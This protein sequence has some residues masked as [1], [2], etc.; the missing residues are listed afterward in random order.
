MIVTKIRTVVALGI[1]NIG[2][3]FVYRLGVKLGFNSVK[4]IRA[5]IE[6]GVF[7]KK[8]ECDLRSNIE[9]NAQ[10]LDHQCYFGW[11]YHASSK[12]PNWHYNIFTGRTVKE[13]ML[14]WWDIPDFDPQLGDIKGVWEASRF[15]WVLCFAQQVAT[16]D[17][18]A[19][20]KLN[21]WLEDWCTNNPPYLG[22]NW[23]CG[24]E[25]SIR[26]MHLAIAALI[27]KQHLKT[28]PA[29]VSLIKAH[30]QRISPTLSYAMA[31]DNNHGTSEAAALY[32]G[33]SW[34]VQLGD[35]AGDPYHK[36]GLKW[37][38]NRAKRLIESDGGFSQYSTT[39]H[40]VMLDTYSMVE[41][42]RQK[43]NLEQFSDKL[44]TKLSAATNWLYQF[45]QFETG[46]APN[47]GAN[48]GARLLPLTATDYRDFRP[49]VQLASVLFNHGK[50]WEPE[51]N[52]DLP[53][54]WLNISIP[55]EVVL[56][57]CST[58]FSDSGYFI[59]RN[60]TCFIML[61]YPKYHFRPSQA[62]ALHL[63]FWL[64]GEN[65]LCD[66]GTYSYNAGENY[67]RYF[68][69]TKSHNTVEFDDKDQMPRLSRF[70][71]GNWLKSKNI[72]PIGIEQNVQ[73][74]SV[75]Y[76]GFNKVR[77]DRSIELSDFDLKVIDQVSGFDTKA[78]LRWRLKQGEWKISG[79]VI[80]NGDHRLTIS[81]S[82]P[83]KRIEIVEGSESRYY[84]QKRLIPVVE[85]E[86]EQ[87]GTITSIYKYN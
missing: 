20:D 16:G 17:K 40:R 55:K 5:S 32:I 45:S 30:L 73:T 72:K 18:D 23:K 25:A 31:Q 19:L 63:D 56:P 26:V 69:G 53:L 42:W 44:Y 70:L 36:Q 77:H 67:I 78:V 39:Y 11:Q 84:F 87:P 65:I 86:V 15:D 6:S 21:L 12:I 83:I 48:D 50:A 37:L 41:V 51:G 28:S 52:W 27:L 64:Q 54:H 49:S 4:K 81:A 46:D 29:L 74:C 82:I 58:Q 71:L 79:N 8:Y 13:P 80:Y 62:D 66:A 85:V 7:F 3:V 61:N 59:L 1:K 75:G 47:L 22:I 43:L 60:S 76:V 2:R 34:L 14:P 68:G 57:Q 35:T 38:E 33:G 24:Q 9:I 10:W